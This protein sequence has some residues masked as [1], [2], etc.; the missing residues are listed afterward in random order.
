MGC[1][2]LAVGD[3]G[4]DVAVRDWALADPDGQDL[5]GVREIRDEVERRIRTL[6][7]EITER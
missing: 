7:D 3:V 1:S 4:E 5:E 6:F 2:T